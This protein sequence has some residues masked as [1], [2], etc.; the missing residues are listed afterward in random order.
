M[1]LK[2]LPVGMLQV[3]CYVLGSESTH[4]AIVI[5]PGDNANEI[6]NTVRRHGLT[7]ARILGTHAHF[8]HL[9]ACRPLQEMTGAPFYLH[10]ADAPLVANMQQMC[11]SWLGYDPGDPPKID[12]YLSGGDVVEVGDLRLEVRLTPGHSPGGVTFVDHANRYAFTGDALFAGSIGRTD[13]AGS[14]LKTLLA[15]IKK[16]ILSLPDDYA[17]FSGHG[18]RTTVGVERRTNPFLNEAAW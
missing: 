15:G 13:F 10:Q 11:Q 7:L 1:I 14:S 8:D 2:T 18:P 16:E 17:V 12:G 4:E 3:N 9:L 5:D 6:I